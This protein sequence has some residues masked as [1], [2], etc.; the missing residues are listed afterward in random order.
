MSVFW[1]YLLRLTNFNSN[2][3][4][5]FDEFDVRS[6]DKLSHALHTFDE[7]HEYITSIFL[8]YKALKLKVSSLSKRN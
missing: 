2:K 5:P 4:L 3:I 7:L 1:H 8:K 6:Y